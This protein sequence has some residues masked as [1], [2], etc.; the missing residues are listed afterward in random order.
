[1]IAYAKNL[2]FAENEVKA[3]IL[4]CKL[5]LYV[6]QALCLSKCATSPEEIMPSL[7]Q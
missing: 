6:Y 1:M 7:P 4:D 5:S 3:L 2:T